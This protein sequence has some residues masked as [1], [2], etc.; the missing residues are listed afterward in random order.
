MPVLR[1]S[2]CDKTFKVSQHR[3]DLYITGVVENPACSRSCQGKVRTM[4][5]N[6]EIGAKK[7]KAKKLFDIKEK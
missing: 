7:L 5:A 1:C 6:N 3:Y 2:Y 4:V